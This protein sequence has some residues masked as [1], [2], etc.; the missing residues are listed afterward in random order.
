[1]TKIKKTI[2]SV[3][4]GIEQP[5]PSWIIGGNVKRHDYIEKQFG[6]FL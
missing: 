3:S 1:M 6:N 2:P 5:K 4:K